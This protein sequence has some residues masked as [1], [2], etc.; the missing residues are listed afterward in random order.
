MGLGPSS[1]LR[2]QACSSTQPPKQRATRHFI[3]QRDTQVMVTNGFSRRGRM[4]RLGA[5]RGGWEQTGVGS[6]Y[7]GLPFHHSKEFCS[8][9]TIVGF[10]SIKSKI[11]FSIKVFKIHKGPQP[12][13]SLGRKIRFFLEMLPSL[14]SQHPP[15]LCPLCPHK[16]PL[17]PFWY[18]QN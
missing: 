13:C 3:T 4:R 15:H 18:A 17:T 7:Q 9:Q 1:H 5:Q 14:A 11:P 2:G 12:I 10:F 6:T 16:H 8:I